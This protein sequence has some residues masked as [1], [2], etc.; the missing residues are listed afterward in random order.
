MN[1]KN[2]LIYLFQFSL[3]LV[4]IVSAWL[5]LQPIEPI[6]F[7]LVEIGLANWST[8]PFLSRFLVS[9]ELI[10]GFLLL[11]NIY[12]KIVLK[13]C[14]GMLLL[15]SVYLFYLL[16]AEGNIENCNCFGIHLKFSPLESLLK[17]GGLIILSGILLLFSKPLFTINRFRKLIIAIVLIVG[18]GVPHIVEPAN[19][20][21]KGNSST[22]Q[23][24]N[25]ID[26]AL[27]DDFKFSDDKIYELDKGKRV[28]GFFSMHCRFCKLSARKLTIIEKRLERNLPVSYIFF[29]NKED[30]EQFWKE[31]RSKK[32]PYKVINAE[33]FFKLAGNKLPAIYLLEEGKVKNKFGFPE[34]KEEK[35]RSFLKD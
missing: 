21:L 7:S 8:V 34:L 35:I 13:I 14:I 9:V 22:I 28:I 24:R 32:Y 1:I 6:E 27:L 30:M 18:I 26:L 15:F 12:R 5:K 33:L 20:Y 2:V 29:G 4:F 11:I 16:Y 23:P 17:N 19:I 10:L 25:S 31:S 3:G